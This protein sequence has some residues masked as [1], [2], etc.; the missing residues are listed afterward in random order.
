[1]SGLYSKISLDILWKNLPGREI[2]PRQKVPEY[3]GK[4]IR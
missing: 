1:M 4:I 3:P 2:Q